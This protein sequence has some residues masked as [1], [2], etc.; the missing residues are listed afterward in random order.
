MG[1]IEAN[2]FSRFEPAYQ[3]ARELP[4]LHLDHRSTAYEAR[5]PFQSSK[6]ISKTRCPPLSDSLQSSTSATISSRQFF[7]IACEPFA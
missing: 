2:Y 7:T 6:P 4:S 1:G 5:S 3:A